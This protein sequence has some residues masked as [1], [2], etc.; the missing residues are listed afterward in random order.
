MPRRRSTDS[1]PARSAR[2]FASAAALAWAGCSSSGGS[3]QPGDAGAS[4]D[5]PGPDAGDA[6][7][8]DAAQPDTSPASPEASSEAAADAAP[9]PA[10]PVDVAKIGDQGGATV[11]SPVIVTVTWSTDAN[12]AAWQAFDDTIGASS[13]WHSI[14]SEYDVGA[15]AGGGHVSITTTPPP[16]LSN[17]DLDALVVSS[18]GS[19]WPAATANT[20]YA[21]YLP[22]GTGLFLNGEPDAGGT[23]ACQAGIPGFHTESQSSQRL[24]YAVIPQCSGAL[25]GAITEAASLELNEA[26]TN[27]HTFTAPAYAGFDANHL[28]FELLTGFQ[29]EVG[30][31]C[32]RV[33]TVDTTTEPAFAYSV[34][35]QWSNAS[36][37]GGHDWCVPAAGPAFY[38]TTLLQTSSESMVSVDLA[39]LGLGGGAVST[40]GFA[41]TLGQAITIPLGLFSDGPTAGPWNLDVDMTWPVVDASGAAIQNGTATTALDHTSGNNGDTVTLTVTPT[42]WSSLGVVYLAVRSLLP[43]QTQHHYTPIVIGQP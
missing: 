10:F 9:Y 37:A 28:S 14:N 2:L 43:G 42:A 11:A 15:A 30:D 3:A 22:P 4:T 6:G 36:A 39:P 5:S 7:P 26:A 13:Y 38:N 35:R 1:R 27:P 41:G 19:S 33:S 21:I 32:R 23:D 20:I 40:R 34:A 17:L 31:A 25:T 29:D 16:A 8:D 12:A 18:A 24:V